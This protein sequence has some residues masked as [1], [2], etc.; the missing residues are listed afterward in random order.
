[1]SQ[2]K[3]NNRNKIIGKNMRWRIQYYLNSIWPVYNYNILQYA[4][5]YSEDPVIYRSKFMVPDTGSCSKKNDKMNFLKSVPRFKTRY[6]KIM[7]F[8]QCIVTAGM[9][10]CKKKFLKMDY[11]G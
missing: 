4:I 1:M 6:K 11:W 9:R 10:L 3:S 5:V 7:R 2:D 8:T